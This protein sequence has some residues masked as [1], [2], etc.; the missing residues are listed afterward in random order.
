MTDA[1][2]LWA[3]V[4]SDIIAN[5]GDDDLRYAFASE[6]ERNEPDEESPNRARAEFIRIQLTLSGLSPDHA[7]YMRLATSAYALELRYRKQ[8]IQGWFSE[9]PKVEFHRGFVELI[10]VPARILRDFQDQLFADAPIEHLDIVDLEGIRD[11]ASLLYLLADHG[12]LEKLVSLGLDGQRLT[13]VDQR[14]VGERVDPIRGQGVIGV[15][16]A[17]NAPARGRGA[18]VRG[19]VQAPRR[20]PGGRHRT[21]PQARD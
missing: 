14:L 1:R 13:G 7:E 5:P 12:H 11:L 4:G 18:E 20:Q 17:P 19:E 21:P 8:W 10:A 9:F 2:E 6:L 16:G 15:A 3:A